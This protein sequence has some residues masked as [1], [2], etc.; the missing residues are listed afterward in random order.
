MA[1]DRYRVQLTRQ[2]EKDF[3]RLRSTLAEASQ[4][5]LALEENPEAGELLTGTLQ[6]VRSLH[7]RVRRIEYRAA[8][9]VLEE[10]GVC[11][12]FQVGT[13]ENFY[14]EAEHRR[15]ALQRALD[16][17]TY[18]SSEGEVDEPEFGQDVGET[19]SGKEIRE[20]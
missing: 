18:D 20:L 7:W 4:A 11:V 15:D 12:V 10:A 8:Y 2:A 6:G 3:R 9:V 1:S 5:L 16:A 13:R 14:R 19:G 17:G